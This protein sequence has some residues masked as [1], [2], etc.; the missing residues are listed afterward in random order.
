MYIYMTLH[1]YK[2]Y[3]FNMS[4]MSNNARKNRNS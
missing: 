2:P 1:I 4:N 3:V